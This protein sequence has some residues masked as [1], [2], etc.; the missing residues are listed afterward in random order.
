MREELINE[1]DEHL[2][3]SLAGTFDGKDNPISGTP[4]ADTVSYQLISSNSIEGI[5]KKDGRICVKEEAILSDDKNTIN[6][7]Y[8]SFDQ[9]GNTVKNFGCFERVIRD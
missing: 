9:N 8:I 6:V 1:K 2:L 5:A 4:F 7:T 3:I